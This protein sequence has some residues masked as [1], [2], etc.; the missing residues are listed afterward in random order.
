MCPDKEPSQVLERLLFPHLFRAFRIAVHPKKLAIAFLAVLVILIMGWLMDL[1]RTVAMDPATQIT[2]L[3]VYIDDASQLDDFIHYNA[4]SPRVGLFHTLFNYGA[5]QFHQAL[6]S[7]VELDIK[8]TVEYIKRC[9]TAV[10]WAFRYHTLYSLI[11][12]TLTLC[13]TCLAGGALCRAAALQ[14]AQGERSGLVESLRFSVKRFTSLLAAPLIPIGIVLFLGLFITCLG[15]VG[16]VPWIGELL[17]GLGTPIIL[18]IGTVAMFIMVGIICGFSL[19]FPTIAFEDSECFV[20]I[21]NSFRFVYARPWRFAFYAFVS[22]IYGSVS[23]IFV[24]LLAFGMLLTSYRFLQL[25]FINNM[26]LQ[27]IWPEPAF[28]KMMGVGAPEAVTW[29]QQVSIGIIRI[30]VLLVVA[31]LIAFIMSYYFSVNTI[32]YAL[33]RKQ[34]DDISLKTIQTHSHSSEASGNGMVTSEPKP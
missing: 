5:D 8:R 10:E 22:A 32:I 11:F 30:S 33:L 2:E 27:A 9:F 29:V 24:R 13:I 18:G 1:H 23:Y 21:N 14:F 31:L 3:S 25:G 4:Q 6:Y 20:A 16:N 15:L 17:V 28:V 7:L 26:K 12:F 19:M 34:V